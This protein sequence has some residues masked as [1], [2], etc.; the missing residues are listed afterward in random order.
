MTCKY[1]SNPQEKIV[2]SAEGSQPQSLFTKGQVKVIVVGQNAGQKIPVHPE[3]L[4]VFRFI[5]GRGK[6]VVGMTFSFFEITIE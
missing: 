2:F 4:S 6:I 5:E 1:F 3:G